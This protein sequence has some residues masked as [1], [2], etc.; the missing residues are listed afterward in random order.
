MDL[1]LGIDTSAYTTSVALVDA[2]GRLV[3]DAR[4]RLVVEPGKKGLRQSEAVFQHVRNLPELFESLP[5]GWGERV[6][7]VAASVSPRPLPE[8]YMPV[9]LCG[10]GAGRQAAAS[11]GVPYVAISHQEGHVWAGFWSAG[12]APPPRFLALHASGGTTEVVLGVSGAGEPAAAPGRFALHRIG[13]TED[14]AAGQMIDRVGVALGLPFP[15]GPALEELASGGRAGALRLPVSARGTTVSF[16]GP[17]TAALRAL[18]QGAAGPDLALAVL[19]C[20]ADTLAR[21]VVGALRSSGEAVPLEAA[22]PPKEAAPSDGGAAAAGGGAVAGVLAVG[23]V[24]ANGLVKERLRAACEAEG[25][26]CWFAEPRYSVDN[27]VG[28]AVAAAVA[29]GAALADIF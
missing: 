13:G 28:S 10:D 23:G 12:Q 20:V 1:Y 6:R 9:F 16:S 22:V 24:L 2:R 26:P 7:A 17:T 15:A 14:L 27:G 21:L 4:R 5:S 18:E 25:L 29:G 8:S 19:E 3:A 11:L